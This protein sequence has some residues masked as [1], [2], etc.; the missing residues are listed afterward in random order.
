MA[1]W[2]RDGDCAMALTNDGGPGVAAVHG[3]TA[4]NGGASAAAASVTVLWWVVISAFRACRQ[5][6]G[7]ILSLAFDVFF[8]P[9]Q[10]RPSGWGVRD[11]AHGR[12]RPTCRSASPWQS[13]WQSE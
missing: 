11:V 8:H 13:D 12:R 3:S 9:S 1:S 7:L 6:R 10:A 4:D 2:A 5:P